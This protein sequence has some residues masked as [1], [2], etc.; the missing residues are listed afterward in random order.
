MPSAEGRSW[1]QAFAMA[2]ATLVLGYAVLVIGDRLPD[3]GWDGTLYGRIT[4]Q[5]PFRFLVRRKGNLDPYYVRRMLPTWV[6]HHVLSLLRIDLVMDNI[7]RAYQILNLLVLVGA[8][9]TWSRISARMSISSRGAWLGWAALFLCCGNAK[10][11]YWYAVLTDTTAFALGV[12]TLWAYLRGWSWLVFLLTVIASYCWPSAPLLGMVL[13]VLPRRELAAEARQDGSRA[14]TWLAAG[15]AFAATLAG[16]IYVHWLGGWKENTGAEL[17]RWLAPISVLTA[18][19]M[20]G[21]ATYVLVD[22]R[23][24]WPP[25]L[26]W[27]ILWR[28]PLA[29]AW[30]WF[31]GWSISQI[32]WGESNLTT[33]RFVLEVL[34]HAI[35]A[36]GQALV[37]HTVFF[38]PII[39]LLMLRLR[40]AGRAAQAHGPG[41]VLLLLLFAAQFLHPE[42]RRIIN[43]YPFLVFVIVQ[44]VD[45]E[46]TPAAVLT[47]VGLSLL[48]SRAWDSFD[49]PERLSNWRV[50]VYFMTQG[51]WLRMTMWVAQGLGVIMTLVT[52]RLLMPRRRSAE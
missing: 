44:A 37:A 26:S 46:L 2:G 23:A 16:T 31:V 13:F 28:L 40:A 1:S 7:I 10:L 50:Y 52:F 15:L 14:F 47:F 43:L 12:F 8:S 21:A 45:E 51:P 41:M 24:T 42:S 32:A 19:G 22:S 11:A 25:R 49:V 36:P 9:M 35:I 5:E 20:A 27:G 48:Y 33:G 4:E 30:I 3:Y 17:L 29:V 34:W 18:A 6:L 39:V 38:G